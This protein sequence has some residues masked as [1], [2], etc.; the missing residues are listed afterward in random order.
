MC[1]LGNAAHHHRRMNAKSNL[2]LAISLIADTLALGSGL[3]VLPNFNGRG[4]RFHERRERR[5]VSSLVGFAGKSVPC[6]GIGYDPATLPSGK[7]ESS[8]WLYMFTGGAWQLITNSNVNTTTH[9][10]FAQVGSTG[11]FAIVGTP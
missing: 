2:P 3:V 1:P 11:L 5:R 7:S 10:V 9:I 8:L 4:A 6:T